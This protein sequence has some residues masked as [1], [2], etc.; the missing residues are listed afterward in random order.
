MPDLAVILKGISK[1]FNL[2]NS[3][4]IFSKT[5]TSK[6][7]NLKS[8]KALDDISLEVKKGEILGIIGVNGSGKSTLLRTI[9]GVYK[10]DSGK[11]IVNGRISPLLQLGVGFHKELN[12]RENIIMNGLLLGFSKSFIQD[13]VE[14]II[15]YAEIDRFPSLQLKHYSTG[16]RARLGFA[17]S[18]MIDPDIF[19]I[20]EILSVGDK[21]FRNKSYQSFKKLKERKKTIL[22]A[23]H[24]LNNLPELADRVLLMHNG[25][26][27]KI[28]NPDEVTKEY[29]K[30]K[31]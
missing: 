24:K 23:T 30:L 6:I 16:M 11:I 8:I 22:I 21:N 13:K 1:S 27:K 29:M 10:P 15:K 14:S 25:K 9:A 17:T 3:K 7:S 4:S 19:L 28:G 26:V 20:D 2:E 5:K 12:A 18:M 31:P